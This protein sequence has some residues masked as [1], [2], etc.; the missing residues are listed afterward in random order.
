VL[1]VL[2]PPDDPPD[3][4]ALVVTRAANP[5][6]L[7]VQVRSGA[8]G[9]VSHLGVHRLRVATVDRSGPLP[10]ERVHAEATLPAVTARAQPPLEAPGQITRGERDGAGRALYE[11]YVPAGDPDLVVRL[12]DPLGRTSTLR[13]FLIPDLTGLS[14]F[15]TGGT[16]QVSA[17]SAAPVTPPPGGGALQLQLFQEAPKA[18][19]LLAQAALHTVGT[20]PQPGKFARSGPGP[21]G[22]FAYRISL[23]VSAGSVRAVR[24][25][26]TDPLGFQRELSASVAVGGPES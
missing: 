26:L 3:L 1:D 9:R 8:E 22:R 20:T 23:P 25:R 24:L 15:T 12:T 14:A 4:T 17:R 13:A 6:L 2:L 16:L 21:D 7:R 10:K 5:A 11:A 19:V 18:P